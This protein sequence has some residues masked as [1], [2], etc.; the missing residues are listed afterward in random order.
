MIRDNISIM[1]R[2]HLFRYTKKL[3]LTKYFYPL[4]QMIL[5]HTET[6]ETYCVSCKKITVKKFFSAR[7]TKK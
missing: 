1:L 2:I 4:H 6:M 7:R 5:L 3:F